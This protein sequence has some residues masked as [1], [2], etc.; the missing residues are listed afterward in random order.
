MEYEHLYER[1]KLA[2]TLL[3]ANGKINGESVIGLSDQWLTPDNQ[4]LRTIRGRLAI[5]PY[6]GGYIDA[7]V[8]RYSKEFRNPLIPGFASNDPKKY[9]GGRAAVQDSGVKEVFIRPDKNKDLKLKE[10]EPVLSFDADKGVTVTAF[11]R[12]EDGNG[13]IIRFVNL[14]D[15]TRN[16]SIKAEGRQIFFTSMSEKDDALKGFGQIKAPLNKKE[17]KTVRIV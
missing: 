10:N 6:I 12:A 8:V 7:E 2:V 9:M 13:F 3:R 1:N 16:F 17:I 4:C 15:E 11:K 14:S 5:M